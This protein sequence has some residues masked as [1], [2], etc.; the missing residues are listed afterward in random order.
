M[1]WVRGLHVVVRSAKA[2]PPHPDPLPGGEREHDVRRPHPSTEA[3]FCNRA[4]CAM[5]PVT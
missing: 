5:V 4:L 2:H 1:G 3:A